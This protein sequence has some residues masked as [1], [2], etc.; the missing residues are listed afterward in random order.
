MGPLLLSLPP[1][2]QTSSYAT[3]HNKVFSL[4]PECHSQS[5]V[6]HEV[7]HQGI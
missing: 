2:A 6:R 5:I 7:I 1:L 4:V 3:A